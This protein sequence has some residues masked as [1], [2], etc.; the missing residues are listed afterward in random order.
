[1]SLGTPARIPNRTAPSIEDAVVLLR[2]KR[3]TWGPNKL[4]F[5]LN[6]KQPDVLWPSPSTVGEILK[7]KGLIR[8]RKR[9]LRTEWMGGT[10]EGSS[11]PNDLWAIDFKGHFGLQDG[12]R[13]HPLTVTDLWSRYLLKCEGL[14]R[15][16][17]ELVQ[18][19]LELTFR[20]FGIPNRL[21]SDNGPPFASLAPGG[22]CQLAVWLIQLGVT[23]ERIHPRSPQENGS[24]ERMHRTLKAEATRPPKHDLVAQQRAFDE[25]RTIFNRERPHE[26]LGQKP[27][28]SLYT[29]PTR[30]FPAELK[31]P[32]YP[33]A[34][35]VRRTNGRGRFRFKQADI[36]ISKS[37]PNA[38]VGLEPINDDQWRVVY[39]PLTLGF[40]DARNGVTFH[41]SPPPLEKSPSLAPLASA[42]VDCQQ[43]PQIPPIPD[44]ESVNHVPG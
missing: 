23:P 43:Q 21:R 26:A 19:Q 11:G 22:L 31:H 35:A 39:G 15:E 33:A 16:C 32:E 7:R 14:M 29:A 24:H 40:I 30:P 8:P 25:F 12:T 2:K 27:P 4:L 36:H 13:C 17:T 34:F 37:L 41:R 42:G 38:P 28:A 20:E 9:R 1:M 18:P 10:L 3:P 5:E 44:P 6:E